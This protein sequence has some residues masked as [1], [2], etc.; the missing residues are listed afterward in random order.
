MS[1]E[2]GRLA[3]RTISVVLLAVLVI[4]AVGAAGWFLLQRGQPSTDGRPASSLQSTQTSESSALTQAVNPVSLAVRLVIT[5][6]APTG[7]CPPPPAE[8]PAADRNFTVC[9]PDGTALLELGPEDMRVTP[10]S[11]EAVLDTGGY[12]AVRITLRSES[13][14]AYGEYT[15]AHIDQRIALLDRGSVIVAA[16]I[17]EPITGGMLQISGNYT[18]AQAA[19]LAK[20]L[21]GET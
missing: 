15:G 7:P 5:A 17:Q 9:S 13:Q 6:S 20:R 19:D 8:E 1:N 12:N 10:Q 21:R 2:R 14:K 16:Q 3:V 11:A 18:A 4:G